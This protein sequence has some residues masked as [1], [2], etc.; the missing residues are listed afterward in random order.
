MVAVFQHLVFNPC[1]GLAGTKFM[2]PQMPMNLLG[3]FLTQRLL[4]CTILYHSAGSVTMGGGLGYFISYETGSFLARCI[5]FVPRGEHHLQN[6]RQLGLSNVLA[7]RRPDCHL[8]E[9]QRLQQPLGA[10]CGCIRGARHLQHLRAFIT[11]G[12]PMII[13]FVFKIIFPEGE[14]KKI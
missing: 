14:A 1:I 12:V 7:F 8:F 11:S 9:L 3:V 10:D 6:P 13:F 5:T 2:W 4:G